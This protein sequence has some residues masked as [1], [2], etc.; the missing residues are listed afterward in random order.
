MFK[1]SSAIKVLLHL[2]IFLF[3]AGLVAFVWE[4][5]PAAG[6]CVLGFVSVFAFCY[7]ALTV[8]SYIYLNSPYSTEFAWRPSQRILLATFSLIKWSQCPEELSRWSLWE[9]GVKMRIETRR[10]WLKAGLKKSFL[11]G[12]I[13]APSEMDKGALAWTLTVLD[14]DRVFED[15]VAR[16]PGFFDSDSISHAS[17]VMLSLMDD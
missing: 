6:Y 11:D 17:S 1:L 8:L 10:K 16:I 12:A 7:A 14:D 4:L 5:C 9:E 13:D 2:S 15:F 3:F